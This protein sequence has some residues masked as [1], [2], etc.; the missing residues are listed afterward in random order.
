MNYIGSVAAALCIRPVQ[1]DCPAVYKL[2][3]LF[4]SIHDLFL[5]MF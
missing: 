4:V 2:P 1:V 5:A 3:D